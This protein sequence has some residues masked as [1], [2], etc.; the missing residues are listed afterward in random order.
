MQKKYNQSRYK[1]WTESQV[2]NG[3]CY[4]VQ[5]KFKNDSKYHLNMNTPS[6][7]K[8]RSLDFLVHTSSALTL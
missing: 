2:V 5:W 7:L 1:W 4:E 3:I 6:I 8:Y